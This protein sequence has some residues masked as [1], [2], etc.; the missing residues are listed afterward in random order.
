MKKVYEVVLRYTSHFV[1]N[2]KADSY[3]EAE[4]AAWDALAS[5][6][7]IEGKWEVESI[8]EMEKENDE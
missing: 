7:P 8:D 1:T 2:V 5:R 4:T 6:A 3:S